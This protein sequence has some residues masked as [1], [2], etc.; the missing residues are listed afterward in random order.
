MIRAFVYWVNHIE[1]SQ[2]PGIRFVDQLL[3]LIHCY[4]QDIALPWQD[5]TEVLGEWTTPAFCVETDGAFEM[6]DGLNKVVRGASSTGLNV[7]DHTFTQALVAMIRVSEE[8]GIVE[9]SPICRACDLF[10]V[11]GGAHYLERYGPENGYR[12]PSKYCGDM[13]VLIRWFAA[14][15][16]R[17]ILLA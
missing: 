3:Q 9:C 13:Q 1:S 14:F 11:C 16:Q 8:R 2:T 6:L 4:E 17:G 15:Y 5:Y 10:A 12:N 7:F